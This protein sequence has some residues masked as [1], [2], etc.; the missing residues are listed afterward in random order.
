MGK[1]FMEMNFAT[2]LAGD[3]N[4]WKT[5]DGQSPVLVN[6]VER[7]FAGAEAD[8]RYSVVGCSTVMLGGKPRFIAPQLMEILAKRGQKFDLHA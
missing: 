2:T 8:A 7:G 6:Q 3:T 1:L 4:F 5:I